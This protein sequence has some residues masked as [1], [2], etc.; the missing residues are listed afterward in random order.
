MSEPGVN[1]NL[2]DFPTWKRENLD[3]FARDAYIKLQ[4]QDEELQR[5]RLEVKVAVAE[6]KRVMVG[7]DYA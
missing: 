3:R 2:P 7:D 4:Q 1:N 6:L 5:L